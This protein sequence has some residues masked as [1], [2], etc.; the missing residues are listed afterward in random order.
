MTALDNGGLDEP[1]LSWVVLVVES[2]GS[3]RLLRVDEAQ[4]SDVFAWNYSGGGPHALADALVSERP[5]ALAA[6]SSQSRRARSGVSW[7]T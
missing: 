4:A 6:A 7:H 2:D 1:E 5:K 3:Q